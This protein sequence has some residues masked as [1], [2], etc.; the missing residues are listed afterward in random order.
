[1][2]VWRWPVVIGASCAAGLLLGLVGDGWEDWL[3]CAL[4]LPPVAIFLWSCTR[5]W[6]RRPRS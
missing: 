5:M 4:L 3:A 6:R 1:M 2:N